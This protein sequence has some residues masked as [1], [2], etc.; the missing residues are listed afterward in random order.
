MQFQID[1]IISYPTMGE[2]GLKILNNSSILWHKA[3]SV[4][5]VQI[6]VILIYNTLSFLPVTLRHL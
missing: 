5:Q 2:R 3:S 6:V 4:V 1:R